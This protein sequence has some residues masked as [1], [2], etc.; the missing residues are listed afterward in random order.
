MAEGITRSSRVSDLP[1][2]R[3]MAMAR[4]KRSSLKIKAHVLA[5]VDDSAQRL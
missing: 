1:S 4:I 5:L 2:K 3:L